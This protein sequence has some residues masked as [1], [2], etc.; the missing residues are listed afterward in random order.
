MRCPSA[1]PTSPCAAGQQNL[2]SKPS[3]GS[4]CPAP[5]V[6]RARRRARPPAQPPAARGQHA[7]H[8]SSEKTSRQR[9]TRRGMLQ[10]IQAHW[11]RVWPSVRAGV[12]PLPGRGRSS[13]PPPRYMRRAVHQNPVNPVPRFRCYSCQMAQR[14]S[15]ASRQRV[16]ASQR[17][18]AC[19]RAGRGG[20][21][22][23]GAAAPEAQE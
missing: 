10:G 13:R 19:R 23:L 16:S 18:Q 3:Q 4:P 11:R 2:A 7:R 8:R 9:L 12:G 14:H 5:L 20:A 15:G 1:R 21:A 17:V 22:R 6:R